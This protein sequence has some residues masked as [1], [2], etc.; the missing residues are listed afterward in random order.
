MV[1]NAWTPPSSNFIRRPQVCHPPPPPPPP[2]GPQPLFLNLEMVCNF[3]IPD[4][5]ME[6]LDVQFATS[7]GL[8]RTPGTNIWTG[9]ATA[10][11][12]ETCD[13]YVELASPTG[14]T[15]VTLTIHTGVC[16]D[17][18]A[19]GSTTAYDGTFPWYSDTFDAAGTGF[20][21]GPL[22]LLTEA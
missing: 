19:A 12:L 4:C 14:T 16:G 6:G 5:G 7:P 2:I 20:S 21:G 17:R 10:I 13:I 1:R 11:G 15:L 18:I 3:F 9:Q 8:T 22:F